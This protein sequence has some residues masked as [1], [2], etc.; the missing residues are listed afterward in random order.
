MPLIASD[1][2][3][4][5]QLQSMSNL[6]SKFL[7]SLNEYGYC[8]G[9]RSDRIFVS[10]A[11]EFLDAVVKKPG[12]F[13]VFADKFTVDNARQYYIDLTHYSYKMGNQPIV[14]L[15]NGKDI[16]GCARYFADEAALADYIAYGDDKLLANYYNQFIATEGKT[17]FFAASRS[18][19]GAFNLKEFATGLGV[20]S[21]VGLILYG[22][23]QLGKLALVPATGGASLVL[24]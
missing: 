24:P 7:K 5:Q 22:L 6:V 12:G 3:N 21:S 4:E 19:E 17:D 10:S 1:G 16:A 9:T 23:Y 11:E 14:W 18:L 8:V 13:G 2:L 15:E 20:S